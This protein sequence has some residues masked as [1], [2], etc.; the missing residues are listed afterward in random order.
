MKKQQK[1]YDRYD[2]RGSSYEREINYQGHKRDYRD[3][4]PYPGSVNRRNRESSTDR[5]YGRDRSL[6]RDREYY[7]R[8]PRESS[9][10]RND[11]RD[12][13]NRSNS[14]DRDNR[15]TN[16]HNYKR[17]YGRDNSRERTPEQ[18]RDNYEKE[19]KRVTCYKCNE[20]GHYADRCTL[21]KND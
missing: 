1:N 7:N 6:S 11:N 2:D 20:K 15:G 14:R 21:S 17:Q 10:Y 18:Y 3:K 12:H 19:S 8:R 13:R 4:S 5:K 16:Y 9:P